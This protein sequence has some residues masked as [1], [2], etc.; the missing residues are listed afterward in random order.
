MIGM[1][2]AAGAG[3]GREALESWPESVE[4]PVA[5]GSPATAP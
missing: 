3:E 2:L 5:A 1:V 4:I